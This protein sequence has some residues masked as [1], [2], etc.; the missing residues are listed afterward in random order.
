MFNS[1]GI[2]L[3]RRERENLRQVFESTSALQS[4]HDMN[5]FSSA[6]NPTG[7]IVLAS[8]TLNLCALGADDSAVSPVNLP[9]V[10]AHLGSARVRTDN[11]VLEVT[12]GKV[13]RRWKWTGAGLVTVSLRNEQ[14]GKEWAKPQPAR[15]ADWNLPGAIGDDTPGKLLS[16]TAGADNDEGFTSNHLQVVTTVRYENAKLELQHLI[17]VY[18]NATGIRTQLRVRALEGFSPK[19]LPDKEGVRIDYGHAIAVPSAR[20]DY[21]PL[22]FSVKNV[23]RYWGYFN[24]PGNRHD[25]HAPKDSR[26]E[27][28]V[29][30][31]RPVH[32]GG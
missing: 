17:W 20:V 25:Q 23:R 27:W 8:L 22:D 28:G 15:A 9:A 3:H 31:P 4:A 24:D 5:M 30:D 2:P 29:V 1:A 18:P 14:S 26:E 10:N 6:T 12:T 16:M 13:A 32:F 21:L 11:A 7:L 19:G